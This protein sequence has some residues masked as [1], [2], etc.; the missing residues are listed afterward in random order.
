MKVTQLI[1]DLQKLPQDLDV[2]IAQDAEG[3]G[4]N[5]AGVVQTDKLDEDWGVWAREDY[6]E[7]GAGLKDAVVIWP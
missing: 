7:G 6:E 3:N 5:L 2:Y 1:D 4:F